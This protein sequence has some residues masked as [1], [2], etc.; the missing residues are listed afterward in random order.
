MVQ[1]A[2][3]TERPPVHGCSREELPRRDSLSVRGFTLIELLVV[4]AI[5]AVLIALLLPAV[6]SAREAARRAQC[7]N[8]LKQLG[9]A[10]ANYESAQGIYPFG[11]ARENTG[12]NSF[13]PYGYYVGSSLFV[14]LLP[15]LE[16]QVL[17]NAYNYSLTHWVADNSTVGATGLS[18]LWCPSD[19]AIGGLHVRFAGWG[20]DGSDQILTYTSYAGSMGNFTKVPIKVVSPG[21]HQAV[22][23]QADGLFFYLGWPA[24]NPPVQPDPIAPLNPGGVRPATLASVTDGLSNTLAFGEKA[25]GKFSQQ[26]DV[27]FSIDF[28]YNGAWVSGNFG[29]TLFTTLFPMNPFGRISD[30]PNP[31]GDFFYS[32]DNQEDNFSIAASSYHPGGCNFAFADGSVR[33]LKDTISGWPFDPATGKPLNVGYDPSTCLFSVKP[34]QG[35]YQALSTRA[36]GEVIS[37]DQY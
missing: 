36:G 15:Y 29:D 1:F 10:L 18:T 20:W 8:N 23:Q 6:Q 21:Q 13:N 32:Y 28:Y 26:P 16:Q 14:R 2:R 9:L 19:G 27:F 4:I 34:A 30:D 31:N 37:A 24:S 35:V 22:L 12:P 17:A 7:V 3:S 11:M 33:F 25:H 5:I